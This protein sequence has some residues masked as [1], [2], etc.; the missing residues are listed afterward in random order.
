MQLRAMIL[1]FDGV[2]VESNAVKTLAF[3][4]LFAHYPEHQTT[5][6]DYHLSHLA[7]PRQLKFEYLAELL[8]RKGDRG[9][10]D[11]LGA[12]F[13][14]IVQAKVIAA[15]AVVGATAFLA[16]FSQRL[17]LYIA[18]VTPQAEL[19]QILQA[20]GWLAY[21]Q[22]VFG[23]PPWPKPEAIR[24]ILHREQLLAAEVVFIGDALSDY[25]A[26]LATGVEFIAR[27]SGLPLPGVVGQRYDHLD[28]IAPV[29]RQRLCI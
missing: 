24:Q 5:M 26:A 10:L 7:Q 25:Q 19:Q 20:R 9:F 21:F 8:G 18:S 23:N 17:P 15:P 1:D 14:Q 28:A 13:S 6:I 2:L 29:I 4:E 22:A 11:Q 27:N 16:E 12:E 3:A